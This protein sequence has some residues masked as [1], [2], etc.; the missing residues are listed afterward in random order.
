[1]NCYCGKKAVYN[2]E[3]QLCKEHFLHYVEKKFKTTIKK[4]NLIKKTDK[5]CLAVSG[6]KDSILLMYL[7]SKN[8]PGQARAILIDEGI[9][10]YREK[11]IK[12]LKK[13]AQEWKVEYSII[14]FKHEFGYTLNE[15]TQKLQ[16]GPCYICGVLRRYLLNKKAREMRCDKIATGHNLDDEAQAILMNYFMGDMKRQTR[17]GY[18]TGIVKHEKFV[19]RIKPLRDI[20]EKE[21]RLYTL[22]KGWDISP[23]ECTYAENALRMHTAKKLDELEE[24]KN[25]TKKN[26]IT[27]YDTKI[28]PKLKKPEKKPGECKQCGEPC[29]QELCKTCNL[30]KQIK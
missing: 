10:E 26:I 16:Y 21:I 4:H 30:M 27:F 18:T 7:I 5:L 20:Y 23:V 24:R 11:T 8:Y 3:R 9:K 13:Y 12:T 6:G 29:S 28:R 25:G 19:K 2:K 15:L 22:I 1:M 17:L 14:P